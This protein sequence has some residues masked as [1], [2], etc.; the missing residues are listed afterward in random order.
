MCINSS[1]LVL[2]LTDHLLL[3]F[4]A[5]NLKTTYSKGFP[6]FKKGNSCPLNYSN[7]KMIPKSL[8]IEK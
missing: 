5:E 4:T 1:L 2:Q 8:R 7:F 3:S 6:E